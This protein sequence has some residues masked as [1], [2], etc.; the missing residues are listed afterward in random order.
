[1]AKLVIVTLL[2]SNGSMILLRREKKER[3][4][5]DCINDCEDDAAV[6]LMTSMQ[7]LSIVLKIQRKRGLL[8]QWGLIL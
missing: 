7:N 5:G 3:G 4:V 2:F 8:D 1:M 6:D